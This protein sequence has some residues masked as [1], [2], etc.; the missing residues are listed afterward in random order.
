MTLAAI[1]V[2]TNSVKL[3]VGRVDGREVTPLLHRMVV[4]RLGEGVDLRGR[5]SEA[6]A[7]RTISALKEYRD[8]ARERGAAAIAAAGTQVFRAASNAADVIARAR[9]E[10]EIEIRVL[11]PEEEARLAFLGAAGAAKTP[12]VLAIDIGGGSTEVMTGSGEDL[13]A[14][15]C[16]PTGAVTLTE[17]HLRSDPPTSGEMFALAADVQNALEPVVVRAGPDAELVGIGGTV[18]AL[19]RALRLT[20]G[21]D[22]KDH[23]GRFVAFPEIEALSI[24]LSLMTVKER[25]ALGLEPGRADI[26][27]AGAWLLVAAMSRVEARGLRASARGLRHGLLIDMARTRSAPKS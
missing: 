17:R 1:D 23:H 27:V 18:S 6:A 19:L 3:L 24:R 11:A 16:V 8:L 5:V 10:A 12:R 4:T 20:S 25:E 13:H 22:P 15:W 21:D 14:S 26:V 9:K 2:G 7:D